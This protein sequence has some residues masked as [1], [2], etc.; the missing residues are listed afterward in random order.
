MNQDPLS[1]RALLQVTHQREE[2]VQW[3]AI[4]IPEL[5]SNSSCVH[6]SHGSLVEMGPSRLLYVHGVGSL[7]PYI[8]I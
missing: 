3:Q 6:M 8:D 7:T 4:L 2:G 1:P 5:V